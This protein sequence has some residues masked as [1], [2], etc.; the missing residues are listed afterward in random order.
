L[1][2]ATRKIGFITLYVAEKEH[3]TLLPQVLLQN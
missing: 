1:L 2:V 3:T